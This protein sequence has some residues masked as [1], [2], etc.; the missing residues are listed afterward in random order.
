MQIEINS[1]DTLIRFQSFVSMRDLGLLCFCVQTEYTKP[2]RFLVIYDLQSTSVFLFII[3]K[4][5]LSYDINK[6]KVD[7]HHL[8]TCILNRRVL[9]V[10]LL[11][12]KFIQLQTVAIYI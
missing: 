7:Y 3:R 10:I 6:V 9:G 12:I 8:H 11:S 1:R 4:F 5:P 2:L